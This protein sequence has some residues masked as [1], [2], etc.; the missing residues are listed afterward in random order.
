MP[1]HALATQ[2][3]V[4]REGCGRVS[5]FV[6]SVAFYTSTI[7]LTILLSVLLSLRVSCGSNE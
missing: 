6:F 4:S 5:G 1:C 7:L 3:S 2:L